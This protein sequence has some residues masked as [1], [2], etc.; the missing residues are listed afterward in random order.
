MAQADSSNDWSQTVTRVVTK[1]EQK[2]LIEYADERG[3]KIPDLRSFDGDPELLRCII[4]ALSNIKNMLPIGRKVTLSVS[5][6]LHDDDFGETVGDHIT[7]NTKALRDRVITEQNIAT[8]GIFASHKLEDIV[9][10]EYGHSLATIKCSKGLEIARRAKYNITGT[11]TSLDEIIRYLR[12]GISAYSIT[13]PSK[14]NTPRHF[15]VRKYREVIPEV[16]AKHNCTPDDFTSEFV[17]LL[18]ELL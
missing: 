1:E 16:L 3:I 11:D 14:N 5:H 2:E 18:K 12:K 8:A 6:L 4:D 7:L 9:V 17:R 15:D 10:H 13:F